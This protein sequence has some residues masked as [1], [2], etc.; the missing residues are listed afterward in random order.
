MSVFDAALEQ[1]VTRVPEI[2]FV[3]LTDTDGIEVARRAVRSDQDA[4]NLASEYTTVLRT[5]AGMARDHGLGALRELQIATEKTTA[6]L[7]AV[8]AEY[9]LVALLEPDSITGRARFHLRMAG[10]DLEREFA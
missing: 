6:L 7:V 9:Y 5:V 1:V 2:R 10:L 8:T 3:T 4:Q